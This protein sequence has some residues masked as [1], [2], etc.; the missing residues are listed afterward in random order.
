MRRIELLKNQESGIVEKVFDLENFLYLLGLTPNTKIK[1][2]VNN[3]YRFRGATIYI[4][5]GKHKIYVK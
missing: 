4:R 2:I 5:P 1:K 3:V